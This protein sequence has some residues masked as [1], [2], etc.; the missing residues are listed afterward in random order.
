MLSTENGQGMIADMERNKFQMMR[1]SIL[2]AHGGKMSKDQMAAEFNKAYAKIKEAGKQKTPVKVQQHG[3][4]NN[5]TI[6]AII[7]NIKKTPMILLIKQAAAG[8]GY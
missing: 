3:A 2:K 7:H 8:S 6:V 1:D 4:A 5:F